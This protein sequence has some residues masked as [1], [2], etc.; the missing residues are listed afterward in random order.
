MY[1]ILLIINMQ[2]IAVQPL[3]MMRNRNLFSDEKKKDYALHGAHQKYAT[4][5]RSTFY[6]DEKREHFFLMRKSAHHKYATNWR[7]SE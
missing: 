5:C 7:P 6:F 1:N 4:N 2:L 3:I